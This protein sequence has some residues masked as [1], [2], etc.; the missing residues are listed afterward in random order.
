MVSNRVI[1]VCNALEDSIRLERNISSDSPACSR[2]IFQMSKA[3]KLSGERVLIVSMGRG[4]AG[5]NNT[6]H[7]GKAKLSNGI[8]VIYAPYS[9]RKFLSELISLISLPYI[10]FRLR[11]YSGGTPVVFWNR[12]SAYIPALFI[13]FLL[14]FSRFLDLEDGDLEDSSWT[15]GRLYVLLKRELYNRLC[16]SGSIISCKALNSSLGRRDHLC[17][18]GVTEKIEESKK[19]DSNSQIIFLL[20]GTVSID[21]GALTLVNAIKLLRQLNKPWLNR[22]EFVI[23]GK[24]DCIPLFEKLGNED[25]LPNLKVMGRLNDLEYN[26]VLSSAHVGL[27][28]KQVNGPLAATTFPSKVIEMA[29]AGLLII[30]TDISDV[31]DVLGDFGA[32]YLSDDEPE[33]LVRSICWIF[34]NP[35]EATAISKKSSEVVMNNL[36]LKAGGISLK[37]FLRKKSVN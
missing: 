33:S 1:F 21:T 30:T 27:A 7:F 26:N 29:G 24:G 25:A 17:Y 15:F 31:R 14:G 35:A 2:K 13:S 18:Y 3:L 8:P 23:T 10:I 22:V 11:L 32:L 5:R 19:L 16:S 6:Y 37:N 12:T 9:E 34:D 36:S 20:G 28:L 4:L